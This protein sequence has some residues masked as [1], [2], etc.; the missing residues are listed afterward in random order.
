MF[1]P[2]SLSEARALIKALTERAAAAGR[3]IPEAPEE[4]LQSECCGRGCERC[5]LIVYYDA[6]DAWRMEIE[7][8]IGA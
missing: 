4:P 7:K 1:V 2:S 6:L 5:V 8:E 3:A